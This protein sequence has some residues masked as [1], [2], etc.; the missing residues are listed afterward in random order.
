VQSARSDP[1]APLWV[2]V[3]ALAVVVVVGAVL[4]YGRPAAIVGL[5]VCLAAVVRLVQT[6]TGRAGDRV[7]D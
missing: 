2:A 3:F 6:I 4:M 1:T 5:P 7:D